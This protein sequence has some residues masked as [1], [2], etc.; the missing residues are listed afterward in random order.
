MV[1][2]SAT[3]PLF[4]TQLPAH[5]VAF[6]V[7]HVSVELCPAVMEVGFAVRVSTGGVAGAPTLT[8]ACAVTEVP[9]APRHAIVYVVVLVG[10]TT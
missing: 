3:S 1:P 6:V 5:N 7:L 8:M 2:L 10:W 4:A 9:F